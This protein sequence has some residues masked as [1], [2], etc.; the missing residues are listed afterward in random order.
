MFKFKENQLYSPLNYHFE[1]VGY[2][3][4]ILLIVLGDKLYFML[5]APVVY[6]LFKILAKMTRRCKR[7]NS[8]FVS[9]LESMKW[10]GAIGFFA[11]NFLLLCIA[12]GIQYANLG[13]GH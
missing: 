7:M 9:Q 13:F 12:N 2:G 6:L 5:L 11:Q 8:Y 1:S 3:S 10:N 4:S